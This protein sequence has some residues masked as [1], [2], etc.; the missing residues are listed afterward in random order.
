L[1]IKFRL[2]QLSPNSGGRRGH[3]IAKFG[4]EPRNVDQWGLAMQDES[5]RAERYRKEAAKYHERAKFAEPAYLGDFFRQVAVRYMFM[6]QEA[7]NG[8][9]GAETSRRSE[10][11]GMPDVSKLPEPSRP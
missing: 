8:Q 6:A 11:P 3:W 1:G 9:R 5:S 10:T 7:L 4:G 2:P